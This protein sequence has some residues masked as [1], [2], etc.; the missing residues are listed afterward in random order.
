MKALYGGLR[1]KKI[2]I[3]SLATVC[4]DAVDRR[5]VVEMELPA[6]IRG[7]LLLLLLTIGV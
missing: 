2:C 5:T 7:A 4:V 6:R 1:F 3:I